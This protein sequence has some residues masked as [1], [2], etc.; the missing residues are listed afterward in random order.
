MSS[1]RQALTTVF[2]VLW[3]CAGALPAQT[4]GARASLAQ[5]SRQ[6]TTV[7]YLSG[8]LIYLNAGTNAGIREKSLVEIVRRDTVVAT[9]EVQ[10]VSS[11]SSAARLTRGSAV[12][13]GDTARFVPV[14]TLTP[15]PLVTAPPATGSTN[16][17][18]AAATPVASPRKATVRPVTGRLGLRYLMLNTGAGSQGHV[19]Q[20][21]VDLRIEGHQVNG[22]SMGFVVDARAYRQRSGDGRTA[23]STRVY[24]SLVEY[25]RTNTFPVRIA[26]GRQLQSAL[27][28]IGFFDGLSVDVDGDH[29]RVG[30]L[31]GTQ[32]DY[33]TFQ[34][35]GGIRE[36]GA[37]LQWHN[38]PGTGSLL[39]ATLGG[40][41]SYAPDGINREFAML[42][43][44]LVTPTVSVY[45]TQEV[46]INRGW[47]RD[48]ASGKG[49]TPTSLF[50]T[51][52]V[53]VTSSVSVNGGYDSR[54][55]VRLYRDFLTP[56]VEFD[57][58]LRRG[59]WGG[60]TISVPHLYV[61]V[62][63]RT[64]DG[65]TVGTNRSST[66]SVAVSRVTPLGLGFRARGTSY[67]GPAVRGTLVSGGVEANPMGRFRIEATVG[68]RSDQYAANNMVPAHTTW[69]GLDADAGISRTWYLMASTYREV[70]A[71]DRLLQQYIALSWRF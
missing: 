12:L 5:T 28:P 60:M 37:W 11:A 24:Q 48:A 51:M 14:P 8:D 22:S 31:G 23:G 46:D 43:T 62:D 20:P 55:N 40:V 15:Q 53:A 17:Q 69:V 4:A 33:T 57:D 7:S 27:S 3:L 26:A 63:Q 67:R 42:S 44:V 38:A 64:S 66:A 68:K 59:Y 58:A 54:R 1:A 29:W 10:F 36:A 35:S 34:P 50:A 13:V 47:K 16:E 30:A 19:T 41:G 49:I 65:A 21:A 39:Q 52:R 71:A 2:A 45:A 9:L 70:G 25:Q 18:T 32:P 6:Y 61:S 56:D